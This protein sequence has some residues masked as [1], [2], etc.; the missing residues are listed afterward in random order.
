MGKRLLHEV[1]AQPFFELAFRA[2]GHTQLPKIRFTA[3]ALI[4]AKV[5]LE[6]Q[7]SLFDDPNTLNARPRYSKRPDVFEGIYC[8]VSTT[9]LTA[10][11]VYPAFTAINFSV[12]VPV[13]VIGPVYF[14]E[15]VVGVVPLVV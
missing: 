11:F 4:E 15:E 9:V 13:K 5:T 7:L 14:V 6:I 1:R 12:S 8:T 2:V 3:L 10:E